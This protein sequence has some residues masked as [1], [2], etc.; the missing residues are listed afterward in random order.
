MAIVAGIFAAAFLFA[1]RACEGG[2]DFYFW[3][4][5]AALVMLAI[6]P[7]VMRQGGSLLGVMGWSFGLLLL[8][9]ATWVGGLAAANFRILCRLF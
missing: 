5:G 2:L 9:A 8:G 3:S 1:P 6:L 7:F 4:G